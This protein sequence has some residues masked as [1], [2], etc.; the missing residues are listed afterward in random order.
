[1]FVVLKY[2]IGLRVDRD[3]ELRDLDIGEHGMKAYN[4]FQIFTTD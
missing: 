4:G 3:D 2:T 1:M